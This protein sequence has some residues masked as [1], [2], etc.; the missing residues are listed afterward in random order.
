MFI[1]FD[2]DDTLID[3]ASA[4]HQAARLFWRR[5]AA[6]LPQTEVEFPQAW[7]DAAEFHFGAFLR[8]EC[9]YQEQRRRRIRTFFGDALSDAEADAI[10]NIYAAGYESSWQLFPDVLP[11]LDGLREHDHTLSIISNNGQTQSRE[12]LDHMGLLDRFVDVVTPDMAGVSKPDPGIFAL[13]GE[14]LKADPQQCVYVGDKLTS[15]ARGAAG[16]GWRGVWVNRN[17]ADS[18]GVND[19]IV[20]DDLRALVDRVNSA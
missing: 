16:A 8:G 9:V 2:I 15:D 1:V 12:K 11:C 19:V 18:A 17:G 3:H 14:R 10:F 5:Y 20:I 4:E 6:T 7:H 13:A